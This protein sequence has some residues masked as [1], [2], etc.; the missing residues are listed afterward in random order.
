MKRKTGRKLLSFL[1]TLAML[2]GLMPGMGLTA[3]AQELSGFVTIDDVSAGDIIG[4]NVEDFMCYDYTITLLANRHGDRNGNVKTTDTVLGNDFSFDN[5]DGV[6]IYSGGNF[7]YPYD[8]YG[9]CEAFEVTEID[10]NNRTAT[11]A[12]FSSPDNSVLLNSAIEYCY[13]NGSSYLSGTTPAESTYQVSADSKKWTDGRWYVVTDDVTIENRI[14]I[15]GT[16]RLVLCD[17]VTLN[18]PN[19]ISLKSGNSLIIYGQTNGSGILNANNNGI[20]AGIGSENEGTC[21]NLTIN[22]GTVNATGGYLAAGIGGGDY[23][24][25][26]TVTINGGTVNATGGSYTGDVLPAGIGGGYGGGHGVLNIGEGVVL[27]GSDNNDEWIDITDSSIR[28]YYMR[29]AIG[30]TQTITVSDVTATYGDTNKK[31]EA[32]TNGNGAISYAVKDGSTDYIDVASDGKLT[33]K[34]VPSD[35]K[36]YVTVTAA[37]TDTYAQA[38]KDVTVTINTKTMTVNAEDVNLTVDGQSHGI[39]VNVTDPASGATVKYGTE[40]GSY[41]LDASP[42]QTEVG[43]QTVYYQV[44]ADNYTTYTGSATVTVSDKGTQTINASDVTVTY[45]DTDKKVEATTDGNGAISYAVKDGSTDYIDVDT[46]TGALTIKKVGTATV[47]V[48]AAETDTYA[49]ATKE[50]TVTINKANAVTATVTANNR[51]YDGTD[52]PLVNVAGEATGGEMKYALGTNATTAPDASVYTTDI[53]TKTKAGTYYVWYKVK[54]DANHT[55]TEAKCVTVTINTRPSSGG[56]STTPTTETITIPV[57]GDAETVNVTVQV[58]DNTATVTGADVDKVLEAKNV[59]TVTVDVSA[60]KQDVKEVVLPAALVEK[61]ATAVADKTNDADSMEVKLPAGTVTF[62]EKAVAAIKEQSKG[63]DLHLNLD[64]IKENKLNTAQQTTVKEMADAKVLDAYM[65][66]DGKRISDFEGGSATVSVPYA[67]KD[68]QNAKGV[69]AW[70]VAEDGKKT[71][72]P[73]TYDG[74][75]ANIT[76]SHFS[77]YVIAYDAEKVQ[78]DAEDVKAAEDTAK[79]LDALPAAADVKPED[80]EAIEK[81]RAAYDALTD[82][83]KKKVDPAALKKLTDAEAALKAAEGG[84]PTPTEETTYD[85]LSKAEKKKA[86]EVAKTFGVDKDT[87]AQM[88]KVAKD[89]GVSMDTVKLSGDALAKMD[90]DSSDAK[91]SDFGKLLARATKR[92]EKTMTLQWKK[93]KGADGYLIYGNKC[94]KKNKMKLLKNIK[95]NGTVKWTQKK[96]KKGTYYKYMVVAYKNVKSGKKTIKMPIAASVTVHATTKGAKNTIAKSVK[97]NKTKVSVKKGKSVTIKASE[98]KDEKKKTIKQHRKVKFE[99]SNKKIAT[100]D[101]NGK[102]KGKKKGTTTIYVYAQNGLYKKVK[103]TV[104]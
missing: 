3:Y 83:Q 77:N 81:A 24:S 41:T 36:A 95:K 30:D 27:K 73:C 70:Y 75:T 14:S 87:A 2:V 49:Q 6:F 94:G 62:D 32:S 5:H 52:K 84:E 11:L 61:V 29:A 58:K 85:S 63:K 1:L 79:V 92:A 38:T 53:P 91:G 28:K 21:G 74:K 56:G 100:V 47:V 68:G 34:K 31:I 101:K 48:T 93:V 80:K 51:T 72:V 90:V 13:Y 7:Y 42:T 25:S 18:A 55:D 66:A 96:L 99:S 37:A 35:G 88:L 40:E 33:I 19:G 16:V 4:T 17:G 98:V 9:I 82:E 22:S 23:G 71:E 69:V 12:G 39:T 64:A 26:G 65:T 67:L 59:G 104:K 45:G 15:N 57:S 44:T 76:V 54:G 46:S 43:T 10:H 78:K 97:V 60:L 50:V 20:A 86:D 89:L 8:A 102:I 103:V